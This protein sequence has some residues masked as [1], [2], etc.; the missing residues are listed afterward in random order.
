MEVSGRT[1][2]KKKTP[3]V[4]NQRESELQRIL[5]NDKQLGEDTTRLQL[6]LT[7]ANFF[8]S[9][10]RN[11]L[12]K[13]SFDLDDA[14][15]TYNVNAWVDF[16]QYPPV[17]N[18]ITKFLDEQQYS[19]ALQTITRDGLTRTKDALDVQAIIEGKRKV[20]QNTN[21]IVFL[22]PQKAYTKVD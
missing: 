8:D 15:N 19:Q 13:T 14:Y 12:T 1:I 7:L 22:M 11:N 2:E 3:S 10:L 20:D 18:Y 5:K 4:V 9:D 16:K 6:F 17:R 21:I